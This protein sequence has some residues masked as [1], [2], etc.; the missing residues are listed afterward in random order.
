M[1]RIQQQIL[2]LINI[3]QIY[4]LIGDVSIVE[5]VKMNIEYLEN[6]KN[7]IIKKNKTIKFKFK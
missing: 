5:Q 4:E 3:K 6:K 7:E 2:L 1:D